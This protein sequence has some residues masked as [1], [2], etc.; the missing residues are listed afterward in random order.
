MQSRPSLPAVVLDARQK[1]SEGRVKL[2]AQHDAGSP[3]IQVCTRLTDLVDGIVSGI[4]THSLEELKLGGSVDEIAL[5][6]HGGYGR[7]DLSPYSDLDLM[8]L[9]APSQSQAVVPL[10]RMLSQYLVDAG[11]TLGFSVRTPAQA[12]S[13]AWK[14]AQIFTSLA[15]SRFLIGGHELFKRFFEGFRTGTLRRC[16][17][18]IDSVEQARRD[19]QQKFGETVFLL[20]PNIKR[21]RGGLRDIHLLRWVAFARHGISDPEQL[22]EMGLLSNEDARVIRNG[23]HFYL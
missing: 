20:Q 16:F 1:L 11:F 7:R 3:G 22:K 5:I 19:E 23:Y 8:L 12:C 14:D 2:R 15:E 21:S 9:H 13:L 18:L 6:P 10:A 4:F 17:K